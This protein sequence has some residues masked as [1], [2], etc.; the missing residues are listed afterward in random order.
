VT[1]ICLR[2]RIFFYHGDFFPKNLLALDEFLVAGGNFTDVMRSIRRYHGHAWG[3][4]TFIGASKALFHRV[5]SFI[6]FI[7]VPHEHEHH[8]VVKD[9]VEMRQRV[10]IPMSCRTRGSQH[11]VPFQNKTE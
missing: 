10:V 3:I 2:R 6:D 8:V 1:F 5:L 9:I 7:F 4:S 11:A